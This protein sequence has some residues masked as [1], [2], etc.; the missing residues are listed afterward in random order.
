[1][2]SAK[3]MGLL[4]CCTLTLQSC[5]SKEMRARNKDHQDDAAVLIVADCG[6]S[7][8]APENTLAAFDKAKE[9]GALAL[10]LDVQLS[11]DGAVV[12]FRDDTLDEKTGLKGKIQSHPWSDLASADLAHWFKV[13]KRSSMSQPKVFTGSAS[14]KVES[15]DPRSA[16]GPSESRALDRYQRS[17]QTSSSAHAKQM[18]FTSLTR[19]ITLDDVFERYGSTFQ[20]YIV[21]HSDDPKLAKATLKTVYEFGV[22]SDVIVASFDYKA[23]SDLHR[24]EPELALCY[25]IDESKTPDINAEIQRSLSLGFQQIG[26]R[27]TLV[28]EDQAKR[29]RS[30][31][32]KVF[33][34]NRASED[35]IVQASKAGVTAIASTIPDRAAKA[36][37]AA[38]KVKY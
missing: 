16:K 31:N 17:Y 29:A 13:K 26:I 38:A 37:E 35:Q 9:L 25:L 32:L 14:K 36:I 5:I 3:A 2:N 30:A 10:E 4:F 24:A 18:N 6:A 23:L 28:T 20:Y 8:I 11:K 15:Y 1:M 21:L 34:Y 33:A 22:A 19:L 12:V 27:T 7:E